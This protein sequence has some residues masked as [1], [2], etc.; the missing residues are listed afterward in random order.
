M[1][2]FDMRSV[3]VDVSVTCKNLINHLHEWSDRMHFVGSFIDAYDIFLSGIFIIYVRQY[4]RDF[5]TTPRGTYENLNQQTTIGQ[6]SDVITKC[7]TLIASIES[8]FSSV[9]AFR[10]ILQDLSSRI[11]GNSG[12]LHDHS[13]LF[14]LPAIVPYRVSHLIKYMI[15]L[16]R[17]SVDV[18]RSSPTH[19]IT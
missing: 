15:E 3:E 5:S 6:I 10:R 14:N 13:I 9:K 1:S 4:L 19:A 17:M 8:R 16:P 7:C 11:V 18:T 2:I 12:R